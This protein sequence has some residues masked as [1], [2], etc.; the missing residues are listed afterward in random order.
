MVSPSAPTVSAVGNVESRQAMASSTTASP[1]R[2]GTSALA[3]IRKSGTASS[4]S[5]ATVGKRRE[6][7]VNVGGSPGA[8]PS[9][10][11]SDARRRSS[12]SSEVGCSRASSSIGG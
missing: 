8:I 5:A 3:R 9:S 12:R 11:R 2:S 10:T 1:I 4:G 6:G 7:S